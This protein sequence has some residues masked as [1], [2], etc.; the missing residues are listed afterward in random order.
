MRIIKKHKGKV[1]LIQ[2]IGL[3]I[4]GQ[5]N[6]G[7]SRSCR[8][9]D[10]H[11]AAGGGD[12][13]EV[14]N[15]LIQDLLYS[16]GLGKLAFVTGVGASSPENPR[17]SLGKSVYYTDGL[18]AVMFMVTRPVALSDVQILEW[19]PALKKLGEHRIEPYLRYIKY[20]VFIAL[21]VATPILVGFMFTDI[22]PVGYLVGT[23]PISVLNPGEFTPNEFFYI[24]L[25][26]F[27]LFLVLIFTVERG[28]CRYFCPIGAMLAPFNKIS[29]LKID[30]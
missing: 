27:I 21:V 22:C 14:R 26:V 15:V 5:I 4:V 9:A 24:A 17:N 10:I 19:Y 11:Y 25:V 1:I 12:L 8:S 28:W 7:N 23:I 6:N 16:G 3:F 13:N 18:R 20:I 29:I 2:C 30:S